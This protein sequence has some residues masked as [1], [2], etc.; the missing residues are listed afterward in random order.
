MAAHPIVVVS[1]GAVKIPAELR[2]DPR[3]QDGAA[4]ELVPARSAADDLQPAGD[5]RRLRG[6][7]KHSGVN[8][9]DELDK[10]RL[11]ELALDDRM[12]G[13]SVR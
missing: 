2:N 4:L 11:S 8:L 9:N 12:T 7:F 10:D 13:G 5:W 6:I 3:F 1:E